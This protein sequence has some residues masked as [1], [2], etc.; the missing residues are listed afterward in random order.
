[1]VCSEDA[2]IL[3]SMLKRDRIVELLVALN[4]DYDQVRVQILN[5][6]KLPFLNEM[7][8]IIHIEEHKRI[9]MFNDPNPVGS[10]MVSNKVRGSWSKS[11]QGKNDFHS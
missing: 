2:I 3:T 5:R 10:T 4:P 8:F 9:A 7:F 6:E 1:M 11:H